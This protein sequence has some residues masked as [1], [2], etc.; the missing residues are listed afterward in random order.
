LFSRFEK[1]FM[2]IMFDCREQLVAELDPHNEGVL[3]VHMDG[4]RGTGVGAGVGAE[5]IAHRLEHDKGCI[6]M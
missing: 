2:I 4:S 1:P 5:E 6:V 3:I